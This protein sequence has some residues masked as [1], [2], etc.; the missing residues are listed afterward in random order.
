MAARASPSLVE[1]RKACPSP[2]R[3]SMKAL[4]CDMHASDADMAGAAAGAAA[5]APPP[6]STWRGPI[7]ESTARCPRPLPTPTA[8]PGRQRRDGG[9]RGKGEGGGGG[10]FC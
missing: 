6:T 2:M 1:T 4:F 8:M 5:A 10:S 7:T 9:G 3:T